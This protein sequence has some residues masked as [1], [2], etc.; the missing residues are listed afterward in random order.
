MALSLKRRAVLW[1]DRTAVVDASDDRRVGYADLE[2]EADAMAR[3]LAA[4]G[5]GP[6]DPVAVCSRNRIETLALLFAVRRLGAVLAPISHRL[7]PA[8]VEGPLAVVDPELVVHEP[9][10]RDL[11]RE[12]PDDLT[13]SFEE[14]ARIDGEDY[15]RT[16]RDSEDALLYLHATA[17]AD[18]P[19][20]GERAGGSGGVDAN[21]GE[22]DAEP[23][24]AD[25]ATAS[26][27]V[28][29]PERAVEWNCITAA[30]AWGL[31]RDDRAPTLLPL[32]DPDGLL[33]LVLPLLYVGGRVV[34]L[35]AFAAADALD[36]VASEGVT[37]LFG[38]ATEYRELVGEDAFEA[39]DLDAVDWFGTRSRLPADVRAA[40]ARRAP[41]VRAYGSVETAPNNLYRPADAPAD[42]DCVGRPFP[43]CEVRL[44]DGEGDP[45]PEGAVGELAVRGPVT[46]RGYLDGE[47]FPEWVRT[48]DLAYREDG[49]Y[50]LLGAAAESLGGI[51]SR[52]HP[53]EIERALTAREGVDAA[54]VV[55]AD[56]GVVAAFVGEADPGDLRAFLEG[57][58]PGGVALRELD[59]LDALP[60][61]P[62]GEPDRA[63]LRRELG[64]EPRLDEE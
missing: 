53:R 20:V 41:V 21:E 17:S 28:A 24:T 45:A 30:A 19:R 46:A 3:R 56:E 18:R 6:G 36:A 51:A 44:V 12:L 1:G 43:D 27:V 63:A 9:G 22:S 2:S 47:E 15:E 55:P 25:P 59:R 10:Q 57:E 8:T 37:A 42:P 26:G 48:G 50:Y 31:G 11:L 34:V 60:R 40:L 7:T 61:R 35:R 16:D 4:R 58:L 62:T 5:V 38:G 64:G 13:C 14:L 52:V 39:V 49:D 29:V 54:G 23:A 32:S 33:R